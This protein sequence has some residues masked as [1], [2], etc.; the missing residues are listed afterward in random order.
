LYEGA[1]VAIL[2]TT[3]IYVPCILM[4]AFCCSFIFDKKESAMGLY[5]IFTLVSFRNLN[6]Q[7]IPLVKDIYDDWSL[8][9]NHNLDLTRLKD[10]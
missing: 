10:Y 3:I 1:V 4:V 2:L 9:F 7:N 5:V 8:N 6:H